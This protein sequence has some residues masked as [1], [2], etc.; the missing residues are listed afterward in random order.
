MIAILSPF[1]PCSVSRYLDH[2]NVISINETATS[3]NNLVNTLLS[4]QIEVC[5]FTTSQRLLDGELIVYTGEKIKIYVLGIKKHLLISTVF[6]NIKSLALK[7][8]KQVE[9]EIKKITL[10]HCHWTYEYA[11][12]CIPFCEIVPVICTVRDLA[13]VIYRSLPL[14]TRPFTWLN[15]LYWIYKTK[16]QRYIL[17]NERYVL[18]ANSSYTRRYIINKYKREHIELIYNSIED[19]DIINYRKKDIE[20]VFVSIAGSL[21]DK[22][23]NIITLIK[24][25]H[26]F[27]RQY[28]NAKLLLVGS[29]HNDYGVCKY[30]ERHN[31]QNSVILLGKMPRTRILDVLDNS[32]CMIHPAFEE[33][34]GNILLEAMARKVL[35]IGGIHSGAVPEVLKYGELGLLCDITSY[36]NIY[37]EMLKVKN[38]PKNELNNILDR[39]TSAIKTDYANSVIFGQYA[40]LYKR[41]LNV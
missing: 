1:N 33:T 14:N 22:R 15:K 26:L 24:A 29:Y 40:R 37:E 19:K 38:M 20:D 2:E 18:V 16:I 41:I 12:A 32:F 5:V 7:I 13:P 28:K 21:D 31:L 3:V 30:V 23:K 17:K 9:K 39:A 10:I 8:R 36:K 25:F 35:I 6:P 11:Y 27:L 4:N 34:F